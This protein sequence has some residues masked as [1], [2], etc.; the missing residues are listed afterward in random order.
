[1][2]YDGVKKTRDEMSQAVTDAVRVGEEEKTA[3]AQRYETQIT[4]QSENF[5][6]QNEAARLENQPAM[7][8][9]CRQK[10]EVE[11]ALEAKSR[12]VQQLNT[13]YGDLSARLTNT[14]KICRQQEQQLRARQEEITALKQ[15]V[16]DGKAAI[17]SIDAQLKDRN[18]NMQKLSN[19]IAELRSEK[20]LLETQL[21]S[22][23]SR[24]YKALKDQ[25]EIE[26]LR[27]EI[28]WLQ[29]TIAEK[30][31]SLKWSQACNSNLKKSLESQHLQ[32]EN[33]QREILN[34]EL[35]IQQPDAIDVAYIEDRSQHILLDKI[36]RDFGRGGFQI[37]MDDKAGTW[38]VLRR[39]T[40]RGSRSK[41][42]ILHAQ[43]E[44]MFDF[45]K[46]GFTKLQIES[47]FKYYLNWNSDLFAEHYH[48]P[49]YQLESIRADERANVYRKLNG[50]LHPFNLTLQG[51]SSTRKLSVMQ[52]KPLPAVDTRSVLEAGCGV[53][54]L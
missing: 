36:N 12:E 14:E 30:N 32:I 25:Q 50:M 17:E 42:I 44:E 5:N 13:N 39:D 18:S 45:V 48:I 40:R 1:L 8:T 37:F 24:V 9:L 31:A 46:Y 35:K 4:Q 29:S 27:K 3:L 2:Y 43:L 20:T 7:D 10:R 11:E 21:S 51:D 6:S 16:A 28:S 38:A 19:Q 53:K 22:S 41:F 54:P 47:A 49:E 23:Q 33:L 26:D 34:I 52:I 15:T